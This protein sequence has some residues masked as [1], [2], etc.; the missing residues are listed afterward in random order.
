MSALGLR[1][2]FA[3]LLLGIGSPAPGTPPVGTPIGDFALT[4]ISGSVHR[5]SDWQGRPAVMLVF[6]GAEC[7]VAELYGERLAGLAA[8]FGPRGVAIIGLAS[9]RRDTPTQL[10][11]FATTHGLRFPLLRDIGGTVAARVGARRTPG[12]VVLDDHRRIRYRGRIDDQYAVDSRRAGPR[13]QDLRDAL[14]ELLAGRPVTIAETEAVGCPIDPPGRPESPPAATYGREIAPILRRRCV[15]CHRPG[16]IGPFA[17]TSYRA[18]AGWAEAIAEA[19][20]DGR[21]PPWHADPRYG[22]FANDARPTDREKRLIVAWA[23]GGA[24]EGDPTDLPPPAVPSGDW[25]IPGPDLVVGMPEPFTVPAQGVVDY[26]YFEV[27]PGFREDRWIRGAEIQPGNR[28]VVHHCNVFLKAPGSRNEIDQPGELGS[29][30]LAATTPGAPPLLLPDGMAKR[31]PAGWRLVFVVH[32]SP[33]G[34]VQTDRT[35]IGLLFADPH[36]VRKEVATNLMLDPSLRIP[37]RA[38]DHRVEKSRRFDDDVLLLAMFPHMHLRGK[39]FRYEAVYPD[40]RSEILLDVPRY[41]FNWQHR[42]ELAEPKRLP[43]G[44][45]LRCIAHYDNSAGNPAN[46]DPEATVRAGR[47]SWDEMFNGYYDIA[48]ADQD[49]TRP[50]A[51]GE[52]LYRRLRRSGNLPL[53]LAGA[54]CASSLFV[55]RLQRSRLSG[56]RDVVP[57]SDRDRPAAGTPGPIEDPA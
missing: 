48:I 37:P 27:D 16:Q 43:A 15:G 9:N 36:S 42:Y 2:I 31:I 8:E 32:Y 4:D 33:I 55:L 17:L 1:A 46:P 56:S 51:C 41:D 13:R 40:G 45:L 22:R 38:A 20:E 24:P 47:Q 49:L 57:A 19:V 34:T 3:L 25:R 50:W 54:V 30:C 6:L 18:A 11:R 29:Y 7:P 10:A 21:M 44:T 28:R 53:L 12:V 14:E 52:A 35:R 26:Q 5:L 39:S 23:R